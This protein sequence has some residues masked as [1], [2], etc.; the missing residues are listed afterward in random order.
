[1]NADSFVPLSMYV[2]L[3]Q[4]L[5]I[6]RS[7]FISNVLITTLI[8]SL[9]RSLDCNLS[10]LVVSETKTNIGDIKHNLIIR[11]AFHIL[12]VKTD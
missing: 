9:I 5:K 10:C 2:S 3:P 12:L 11:N 4:Y 8:H 6:L 7:Y 1:M